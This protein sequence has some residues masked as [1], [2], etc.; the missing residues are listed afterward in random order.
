LALAYER[1]RYSRRERSAP[2]DNCRVDNC[3]DDNRVIDRVRGIAVESFAAMQNG[4][5]GLMP[6]PG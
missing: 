5:A 6:V 4:N 1:M 3:R 2:V